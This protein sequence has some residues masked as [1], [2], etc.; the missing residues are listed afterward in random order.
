MESQSAYV[1]MLHNPTNPL[2]I[3]IGT[4][5]NPGP[6]NKGYEYLVKLQTQYP[7][8]IYTTLDSIFSGTK[9]KDQ[10]VEDWYNLTNA[11]FAGRNITI[12]DVIEIAKNLEKN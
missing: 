5:S 2:V 6:V 11:V 12:D 9:I 1:Y 3:K 4:S 8:K 10:G 7:D